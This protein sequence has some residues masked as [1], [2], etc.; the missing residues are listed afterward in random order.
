MSLFVPP[1][2]DRMPLPVPGSPWPPP[3]IA[4]LLPTFRKWSAWYTS[5]PD[6]LAD[7]Y[8]STPI[9]QQLN[10][11]A[12]WAGGV[13]GNVA[14]FIWGRPVPRVR[15]TTGVHVPLASDLCAATAE[16]AYSDPP[17][18][19]ATTAAAQ[20]RITEYVDDGLLQVASG[21][22]E[23]GAAFGGHYLQAVLPPAA[24]RARIV[25]LTTTARSPGSSSAGS[26]TSLSG[27]SCRP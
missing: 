13:V 20:Q 9:R 5:D 26:S 23:A 8:G 1:Y 25:S 4:D 10:R 18:I 19:T 2:A 3:A 17:Q 12:Q 16:L 11:P 6:Q 7:A 21:G 14:R 27:G 24:P 22:V 15:S